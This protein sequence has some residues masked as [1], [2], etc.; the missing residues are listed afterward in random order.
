MPFYTHANC[1]C[2]VICHCKLVHTT[3]HIPHITYQLPHTTCNCKK[4]N[5]PWHCCSEKH[6]INYQKLLPFCKTEDNHNKWFAKC[7]CPAVFW[8]S[9]QSSSVG[10]LYHNQYPPT[11]DEKRNIG[12]GD[13]VFCDIT[14]DKNGWSVSYDLMIRGFTHMTCCSSHMTKLSYQQ[15]SCVYSYMSCHMGSSPN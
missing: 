11:E 15:G 7:D 2:I 14:E 4:C 3:Y 10:P 8:Q 6:H 5:L 1:H 13:L 9:V 12:I